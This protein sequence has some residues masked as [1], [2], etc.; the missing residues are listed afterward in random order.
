MFDTYEE[1]FSRRADSYHEAMLRCSEARAEEFGV[2]I[3]P[4]VLAP[5]AIVCDMPAGGGYLRRYLPRTVEYV[6]V[7]PAAPFFARCALQA[8][9]RKFQSPLTNVPLEDGS[10]DCVV[11]LA[12]LHHAPDLGAI[13]VEMRRLLRPDGTVVIVDVD[14]GTASAVFLNGFVHQHNPL[15]HA[16]VFFDSRTTD[17]LR[18]AEFSVISDESVTPRW[19][20]SSKAQMADYCK[21]LFGIERASPVQV[22]DY[23]EERFDFRAED[24]EVSFGW[25]LRRI[26]CRPS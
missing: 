16:G 14:A 23:I 24:G 13:F 21:S 12:G 19:K 1:I 5:G 9:A 4:L 2:A 10:V 6:A 8:G 11:S 22:S 17:R 25:P 18:R 15:G 3:A 20:F 26:V 7:E